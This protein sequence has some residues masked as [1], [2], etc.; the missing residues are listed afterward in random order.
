[1]K[2]IIDDI[3]PIAH[4][5]VDHCQ[6]KMNLAERPGLFFVE[7]E[8]NAKKTFGKTAFYDPS[9]KEVVVFTTGRHPKDVL[10]SIAHELVHHMQNLRGDFDEDTETTPGYAQS[11]PKLRKME[12]EAYL[13]GNMLFRDWEDGIKA[14]NLQESKEKPKM[15]INTIKKLVRE[16]IIE[17]LKE[18]RYKDEEEEFTHGRFSDVPGYEKESDPRQ[19]KKDKKVQEQSKTDSPDRVAGRVQNDDRRLDELDDDDEWAQE[20]A[21]SFQEDPDEDQ[22]GRRRS[23]LEDNDPD[24][25]DKL[26][27]LRKEQ[28][29]LEEGGKPDFLDLDKDGD[30]EESMKDAA[31]DADKKKVEENTL[32]EENLE[33]EE[34]NLEEGETIQT[35]EQENSLYEARFQNR[36]SKLFE[37]LLSKWVK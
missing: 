16:K 27:S 1:M 23:D 8:E 6:Q 5:L 21:S 4:K 22:Y 37:R 19:W 20:P 30:K 7:D 29:E 26:K 35:P 17:I 18:S 10:R 15:N 13:L 34:E 3:E 28:E 36:N 31:K 24:L 25:G 12:A 14:K 33:E 2:I 11:N 32:E 9:N